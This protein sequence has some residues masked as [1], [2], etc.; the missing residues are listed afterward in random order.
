MK[1]NIYKELI[2]WKN[3]KK[4]KPLLIL[5]QRQIGKTYI[6]KKFASWEYKNFIYVNFF[7]DKEIINVFRSYKGSEHLVKMIFDYYEKNI[8]DLENTLII[9]D[10]IQECNE[11][12]LSLKA[13]NES[14]LNI[15]I[16]ATGSYLGYNIATSKITFPIGQ[17]E[18]IK[19]KQIMFDEFVVALGKENMLYDIVNSI[20]NNKEF[21]IIYHNK[22]IE[23]FNE[24][25]RIGGFPEVVKTY[26]ENN[27][28]VNKALE[29]LKSIRYR[30]ENDLDKYSSLFI[31][32]TYLRLIYKS[33][34]KF[35]NRENKKYIFSEIDKNKRYRDVEKFLFWLDDSNLVIKINNLKKVKSPLNLQEIDNYFKLFYNDLGF[36]NLS[37]TNVYD[38]NIKGALAENFVVIHLKDMFD[39]IYF[40]NFVNN[41]KKYEV[42]FVIEKQKPFILEV[43]NS[44]SYKLK[45]LLSANNDVEKI[46]L[47]LNPYYKTDN[48]INI[49]I[50]LAYTLDKLI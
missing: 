16:V 24:Y 46:V 41:G 26:I 28:S 44:T 34:D 29:A 37:F 23:L 13:L 25:L 38:Q 21:N 47:S 27:N 14:S 30:Y 33:I 12:I 31:N 9:L 3:K 20:Q 35:L 19:M 4:H 2:E 40:Y 11:A 42:D 36:L 49:P 5:G 48:Y 10:E 39:K 1:R 7:D 22:M 17:V 43:K 18:I 45:S 32:K 50:Y 15:N 8:D 6:I